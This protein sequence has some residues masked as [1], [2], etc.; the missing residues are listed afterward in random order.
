[1][2]GVMIF[3]LLLC[4]QFVQLK[5]VSEINY[6]CYSFQLLTDG[7]NSHF[8]GFKAGVSG[9]V[10]LLKA[11]KQVSENVKVGF[12]GAS[13]GASLGARFG[14]ENAV[15]AIVE[16]S[17]LKVEGQYSV[18]DNAALCGSVGL[19]ATTGV[20]LNKEGFKAGVLGFGLT[21]GIGGKFTIDSPFGS[22]GVC[23]P[24]TNTNTNE[25]YN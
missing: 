22:A 9:D 18:S 10:S 17:L 4:N 5:I 19:N 3:I 15:A 12:T 8:A 11:Q 20:K 7:N 21:M 23:S 2:N 1:M 14:T 25:R 6:S 16:P 24:L 13:A